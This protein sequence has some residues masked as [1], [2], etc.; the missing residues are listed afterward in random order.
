MAQL[1]LSLVL[2]LLGSY[3]Q[4]SLSVAQA[5]KHARLASLQEGQAVIIQALENYFYEYNQWPASLQALGATPGY[6]HIRRFLPRSQ[7]GTLAGITSPWRYVVSNTL[8]LGDSQ[9]QRVGVFI[10]GKNANVNFNTYLS[11]NLCGGGEP[12]TGAVDWCGSDDFRYVLLSSGA[13]R[14]T[15]ERVAAEQQGRVAEKFIQRWR[16]QSSLPAMS[17]ATALRSLV[18]AAGAGA[19]VGTNLTSCTGSF[20]WQNIPFDCQDLYNQFGNPV[21]YRRP[22]SN[23]FEL[24]SQSVFR[25]HLGNLK[26]IRTSVTL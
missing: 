23:S 16:T 17:S 11:N 26:T 15:K 21:L 25:D 20:Y 10:E 22:S 9:E 2:M 4:Y 6:E 1:I 13:L 3:G 7:G 24:T 18:T 8:V 14:L 5:A 19:N 12:F